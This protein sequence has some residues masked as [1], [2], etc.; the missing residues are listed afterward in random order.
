MSSW[1]FCLRKDTGGMSLIENEPFSSLPKLSTDLVQLRECKGC[2]YSSGFCSMSRA[3]TGHTIP[4]TLHS[5][6]L[7]CTYAEANSVQ[8]HR[9]H[10]ESFLGGGTSLQSS[11]LNSCL[12]KEQRSVQRKTPRRVQLPTCHTDLEIRAFLTLYR[13]LSVT[14]SLHPV[15]FP[16]IS[17]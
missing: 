9:Q 13:T 10:A 8:P 6:S 15:F 5:S 2:T 7:H 3:C 17:L 11:Q 16:V 14:H 12:V 4:P 1:K